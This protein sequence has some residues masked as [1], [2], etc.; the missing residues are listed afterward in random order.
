MTE[1]TDVD[2]ALDAAHVDGFDVCRVEV[3]DVVGAA[4]TDDR[5]PDQGLAEAARESLS[6]L[7][8]EHVD[9]GTGLLVLTGLPAEPEPAERALNR[10]SALLGE[11]LP[12]N[13]EGL[14]V[15]HVRDRGTAIGEG[16]RARYSDSRFGGNLHTDGV[17]RPLPAPELFTLYCVRQSVRGGALQ[18][19]HVRE[20]V[21][22]LSARPD[23][24]R[25]LREP[26][27]FDRRGDQQPGEPPTVAKPILFEQRG[28][29]GIAYLR[30][31]IELGHAHS[32]SPALS[33]E[34]AAALDAL[35]EVVGGL[36]SSMV[37]KLREGEL[38][39]FDNLSLLHGRTEFQD[40]PTR[41][42][43]LLR[44]WIRVSA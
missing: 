33:A 5:E 37:G 4:L 9:D 8:R 21:R 17:E 42:R 13:L 36:A 34:Q 2:G 29:Q 14:I 28:R 40:D 6:R 19:V 7:V 22:E 30:S 18:L 15:K 44:T 41:A 31:Y 38:A 39:I 43:L 16:A 20:I 23:V 3:P 27:H 32:G 35:D 24:L 10:L 12:Q 11:S 1:K 26:F 25:V